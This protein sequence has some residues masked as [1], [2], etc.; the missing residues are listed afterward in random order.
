MLSRIIEPLKVFSQKGMGIARGKKDLLEC[1]EF[2]GGE[3]T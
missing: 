3:R 2:L 1:F